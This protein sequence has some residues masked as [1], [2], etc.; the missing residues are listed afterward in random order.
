MLRFLRKFRHDEK[1]RNIFLW[2]FLGVFYRSIIKIFS[3]N[4][5]VNQFI[6]ANYQ[7]KMHALFAFSNF[8][9]WGN[10]HNDFFPIYLKLSRKTKCFLDIGAHIGIVSLPISK[11]I[12]KGGTLYSF[13]PSLKNL[14]FLNYHIKINN[15]NNIKVVDKIVSSKNDDRYSFFESEE[16]SGMN[17]IVNLKNK[18]IIV[19][20]KIESITLDNFCLINNVIP[21]IIKVDIEGAEIDMLVGSK[22][23]IKKFKPLIFLSYHPKHIKKLGYNDEVIFKIL[24]ELNYKIIDARAKEPKKL[25][26][27]EYLLF[28]KNQNIEK[29]FC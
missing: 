14:F 21:E 12:K 23:I 10:K 7:F 19:K 13:E 6:S 15:I 18:K 22:R 5:S 29:I 28:P 3:I 1:L 4:F 2:K 17:S 24:K 26:N 9:D 16:P 8:K 20:R 25:K 11:N 27:N